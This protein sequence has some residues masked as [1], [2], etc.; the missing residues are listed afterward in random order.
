M[1]N[2][3]LFFKF[4]LHMASDG[5]ALFAHTIAPWVEMHVRTSMNTSAET[6]ETN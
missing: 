1:D 5:H 6:P 3:D 4:D 2:P